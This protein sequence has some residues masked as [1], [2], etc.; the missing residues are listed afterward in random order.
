MRLEQKN[1]DISSIP[2]VFWYSLSISLLS[3]TTG[4]TVS[5]I[6][7]TSVSVEVANSKINLS[8]NINSVQRINQDLKNKVEELEEIDKAYKQLQQKYNRLLKSTKPSVTQELKELNREIQKFQSRV[9]KIENE[10][11]K[12]KILQNEEKLEAINE[13]ISVN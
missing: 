9:R 3:L 1:M 5:S 10:D 6:F 8:K 4:L 13:Q 2:K 7:A 12:E 11:L